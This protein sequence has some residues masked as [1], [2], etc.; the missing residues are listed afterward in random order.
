MMRNGNLGE[1]IMNNG[2]RKNNERGKEKLEYRL[3]R[4]LGNKRE[5]TRGMRKEVKGVKEKGISL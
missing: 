4:M 1:G 5:E 2:R 3:K